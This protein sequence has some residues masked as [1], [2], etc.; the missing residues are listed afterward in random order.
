M[1]GEMIET[2]DSRSDDREK[3]EMSLPRIGE[4]L[5]EAD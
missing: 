1:S 4:D 5:A 2:G 3:R